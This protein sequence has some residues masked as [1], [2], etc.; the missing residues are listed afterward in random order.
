[1]IGVMIRR[2][3]LGLAGSFLL[4][5]SSRAQA[6]AVPAVTRA[7]GYLGFQLP[8][9]QGS[10]QYSLS[11]SEILTF[12]YGG[13]DD[14]AH[15]SS[16]A[17]NLAFLSKSNQHPLN[18]LYS[19]AYLFAASNEPST[20]VQSLT[21][22]QVY[23]WEKWSAV[24]TDAVSYSPESPSV[25]LSGIPGLGDQNLFP[26]TGTGPASQGLLSGYAPRV[27]NSASG[28]LS[29]SLTGS[30]SLQG[31]GT[32]SILR[33][34]G[35]DA[36]EGIDDNQ[37]TVGGGLN[38]RINALNNIGAVANYSRYTFSGTSTSVTT[39]TALFT[40]NRQLNRRLS[41]TLGVG[42]QRTTSSDTALYPPSTGISV[43]GSL[44]YAAKTYTS[45][46]S[47]FRGT[48]AGSGVVTG[49][50]ANNI[51]G[52]VS[53]RFSRSIQ[54]TAS[55]SYYSTQSLFPALSGLP[56]GNALFPATNINSLIGSAQANY[57][58]SPTLT[59]YASYAAQHQLTQGLS[60]SAIAL[61]GLTQ[62]LGFGIT[63]SPIGRR[64]G[65]ND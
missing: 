49:A 7:G 12:G 43:D 59:A 25:G 24:A 48:S 21:A 44:T 42:P 36:S 39:E 31:T 14:N 10:L 56:S 9:V 54:A 32:Y 30:T 20:F 65:H 28:T 22:S 64:F 47:Y 15:A 63:Y 17:G 16:V 8:T 37:L 5:L 11:A 13:A 51:T 52:G 34:V 3:Y 38:H 29:R 26:V 53:R 23:K 35:V 58:L 50:L 55:V 4:A 60:V 62:T 46:L 6:Q 27:T 41:M 19:G 45:F 33:F 18:V 1:M 57:R 2:L 61:N 40:F